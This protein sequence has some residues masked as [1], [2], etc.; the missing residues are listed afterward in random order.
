MD[1]WGGYLIR[2]LGPGRQVFIDGRFDLY[3]YA[4]VLTDYGR[5]ATAMPNTP[6]LLEK[7]SVRTCLVKRGDVLI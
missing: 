2:E 4:G 1:Q 6:R 7:Y 5:I 3:D